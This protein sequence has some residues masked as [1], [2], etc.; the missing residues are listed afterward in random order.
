MNLNTVMAG[1][2]A[3]YTKKDLPK[4]RV[5]DRVKVQVQVKDRDKVKEG[6]KDYRLQAFEGTVIKRSGHGL[7]QSITVRTVSY[8]IGIERIFP[9][10]APNVAELQVVSH[11]KTRRSKLYYLRT[12]TSRTARLIETREKEPK[13]KAPAAKTAPAK[14]V[15][16]PEP[17]QA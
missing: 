8:G 9:I 16:A 13:G 7:N 10:H 11:H 4:F 3:A 2:E 5:G 14:E 1:V 17:A 6:E 15:P 12:R